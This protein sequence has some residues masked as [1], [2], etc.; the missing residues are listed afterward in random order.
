MYLL[1]LVSSTS[2]RFYC[3]CITQILAYY[4]MYCLSAKDISLC[5]V[6][7]T[8]RWK[9]VVAYHLT[10]NSV[11]GAAFCPIITDI[12]IKAEHIGL[13]VVPT[14]I[15]LYISSQMSLIWLRIYDLC[16]STMSTCYLLMLLQSII[17]PVR[18]S[19]LILFDVFLIS[20][21]QKIFVWH[22]SLHRQC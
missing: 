9:Q 14:K 4:I 3:T 15:E 16:S 7:L 8:T 22:Q 17:Y 2:S 13:Q 21:N 19:P 5:I 18:L 1:F 20:S 6:G 12:I 10:P 11:Q